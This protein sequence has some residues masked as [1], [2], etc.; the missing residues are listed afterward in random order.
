MGRRQHNEDWKFQTSDREE[1]F[2]LPS[3]FSIFNSV[4]FKNALLEITRSELL[5]LAQWAVSGIFNEKSYL[6]WIFS[7]DI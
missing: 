6:L 2:L 1:I 4:S 5:Q 3:I 7:K